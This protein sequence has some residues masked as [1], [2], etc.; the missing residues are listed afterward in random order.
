[1]KTPKSKKK[2]N[3]KAKET[4]KDVDTIDLT[5]SPA[6]SSAPASS[7][8]ARPDAYSVPNSPA[9]SAADKAAM[10]PPTSRPGEKSVSRLPISL[11][12][13]HQTESPVRATDNSQASQPPAPRDPKADWR[14]AGTGVHDDYLTKSRGNFRHKSLRRDSGMTVET[15]QGIRREK[16][17]RIQQGRWSYNPSQ[18]TASSQSGSTSTTRE[19][20][21]GPRCHNNPVC[22][23]CPV[24][25]CTAADPTLVWTHA[26]SE[27]TR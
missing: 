24:L 27:P 6:P 8:A 10:P 16:E 26:A 19:P 9:K 7:P 20:P 15:P 3:K 12:L 5:S 22:L 11:E 13:N 17:M 4:L 23:T 14:R 21:R 1:M 25:T 18:A 2:K